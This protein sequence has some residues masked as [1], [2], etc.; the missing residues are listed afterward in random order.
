MKKK[1]ALILLL[2]AFIG[3]IMPMRALANTE[4]SNYDYI[5]FLKEVGDGAIVDTGVGY[6]LAN[7]LKIENY[8]TQNFEKIRNIKEMSGLNKVQIKEHIFLI[9]EEGNRTYKKTALLN[10]SRISAYAVSIPNGYLRYR[11]DGEYY[12]NFWW[13][14]STLYLSTAAVDWAVV[15]NTRRLI[16]GEGLAVLIGIS[17][18]APIGVGVGFYNYLAGQYNT[19]LER[20]RN[21]VPFFADVPHTIVPWKFYK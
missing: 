8:I 20:Q 3:N 21:Y 6:A 17:G 13:G 9:L 1:L 4:R 2:F 14:Q 12:K 19:D 16:M 10:S 5:T 15:W 7:E 18:G 11:H